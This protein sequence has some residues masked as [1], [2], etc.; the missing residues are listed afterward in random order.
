MT[1]KS[2]ITIACAVLALALLQ[3]CRSAPAPRDEILSEGRDELSSLVAALDAQQVDRAPGELVVRLAFGPGA[4]LDLFVTAPDQESVYF[5]N[6]PTR[7]GGSLEEDVRCGGTRTAI[8]RVVFLA[9]PPGSYR[10]GIDFPRRCDGDDAAAMYAV[11]VEHDGGTQDA[12]GVIRPGEFLV[13]V[14]HEDVGS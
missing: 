1:S 7:L 8:E 13:R 9:A 6:S 5:A 2:K 12:R 3:G 14:L 11:R 10:V 4:D